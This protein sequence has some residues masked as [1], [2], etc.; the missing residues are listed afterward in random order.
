MALLYTNTIWQVL[1]AVFD[2][3][4]VTGCIT[5]WILVTETEI[6]LVSSQGKKHAQK[7]RLYIQMRGKKDERQEDGKEKKTDCTNFQVA[8]P[9]HC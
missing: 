5:A 3:V 4:P 9:L 2:E 7:V 8:I 1:K 6:I